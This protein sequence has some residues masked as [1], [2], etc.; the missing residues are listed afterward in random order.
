MSWNSFLG[1]YPTWDFLRLLN[2]QVMSSPNS[3]SLHPLFLQMLFNL[4]FS[5]LETDAIC[6]CPEFLRLFIFFPIY[7]LS[8]LVFKLGISHCYVFKCIL[9]SVVF[10]VLL[11]NAS[12]WFFFI[13]FI[14][15][16]NFSE[17]FPL[18]VSRVESLVEASVWW[19]L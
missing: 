11:L 15:S 18:F 14:S 13:S 12:I 6:H 10:I 16:L 19:L 17:F 8:G 1:V 7:F 2:L 3:R 4:T 5:S 9:L